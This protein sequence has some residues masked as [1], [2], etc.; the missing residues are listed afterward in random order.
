LLTV[1]AL[2]LGLAGLAALL[3][4]DALLAGV[5][6]PPTSLLPALMQLLGALYFAFALVNW[7]ARDSA[8]GGIYGR[9]V[10]LGNFAHFTVGALALVK[11][12]ASGG[13]SALVIGA[14]LVYTALAVI[15]GW[16]LF[17]ARGLPPKPKA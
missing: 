10:G 14:L 7:T 17:V 12:V 9:P 8:F 11:V 6:A 16:L 4:A 3:A 15:F 5:T 1:T 2:L 13:A